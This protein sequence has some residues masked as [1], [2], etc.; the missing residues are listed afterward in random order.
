MNERDRIRIEELRSSRGQTVWYLSNFITNFSRAASLMHLIIKELRDNK[1]AF[2]EAKRNYIISMASVLETFY[3]DLFIHVLEK[4]KLVL[5]TVL[6]EVKKKPNLVEVLSLFERNISFPELAASCFS[7]QSIEEIDRTLDLIFQPKNYLKTLSIYEPIFVI[8]SKSHIPVKM[9][10]EEGWE[11]EF[12]NIFLYRHSFIHDS[13]R[14]CEIPSIE[15]GRLETLVLLVAQFTAAMVSQKYGFSGF[16][17]N[18]EIAFFIIEDLISDDWV[19]S[20]NQDEK[21]VE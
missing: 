12:K 7:F 13:N 4:D 14:Q 5:S 20:E 1:F 21:L 18:G 9:K 10:L 6:L 3:R 16:S 8:P 17:M 15:V 19:V 2:Q 11:K